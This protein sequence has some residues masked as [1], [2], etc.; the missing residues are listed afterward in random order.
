MKIW[1][2]SNKMNVLPIHLIGAIAITCAPLWRFLF[3]GF[4]LYVLLQKIVYAFNFRTTYTLDSYVEFGG[5]LLWHHALGPNFA[6]AGF[7]RLFLAPIILDI[8]LLTTG[9]AYP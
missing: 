7:A 6:K 4:G 9:N 8:G 2:L 5:G 1:V 3:V